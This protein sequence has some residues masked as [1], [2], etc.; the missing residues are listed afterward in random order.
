MTSDNV[1]FFLGNGAI[2]LFLIA[3]VGLFQKLRENRTTLRSGL[4]AREQIR[5][6]ADAEWINAYRNAAETHLQY[7]IEMRHGMLELRAQFNT[8]ERQLNLKPTAWS[9]V[10]TAP[11]LFPSLPVHTEGREGHDRGF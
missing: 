5:H 6:Q 7:D 1:Q 11:P 2:T 10:P 8:L 9:P 3:L 4:E